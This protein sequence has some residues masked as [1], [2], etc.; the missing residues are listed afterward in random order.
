MRGRPGVSGDR[1][2]LGC[3]HLASETDSR[4][5]KHARRERSVK[6]GPGGGEE[7]DYMEKLGG[8]C[9]SIREVLALRGRGSSTLN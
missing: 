3:R 8:Y 2:D 4:Q 7:S 6:S 9:C 5:E 1:L